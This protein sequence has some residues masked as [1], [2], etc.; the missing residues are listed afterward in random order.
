[1]RTAALASAGENAFSKAIRLGD[2]RGKKKAESPCRR[3]FRLMVRDRPQCQ[4]RFL[5]T[6]LRGGSAKLA[7]VF[8]VELGTAFIADHE[9]RC[10]R[11]PAF[12]QHQAFSLIQAQAFLKLERTQAGHF[13]K[14]AIER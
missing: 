8:P 14:M 7:L 3:A 11:V 4:E 5:A 6:S 12:H 2:E 1:M 9:R 13:L 10:S